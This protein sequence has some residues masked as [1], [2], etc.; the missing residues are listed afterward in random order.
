MS[1]DDRKNIKTLQKFLK[2]TVFEDS[3]KRLGNIVRRTQIVLDIE[4]Q[5]LAAKER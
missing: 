4:E 2:G 1:D 5:M 3:S